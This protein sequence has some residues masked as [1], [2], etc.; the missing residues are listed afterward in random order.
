MLRDEVDYMVKFGG[1]V[2]YQLLERDFKAA[3]AN[4]QVKSILFYCN[5]PGGS[6]IIN[7]VAKVV[8][9]TLDW[10]LDVQ[11]AIALRLERLRS[12]SL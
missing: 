11:Q 8:V 6:A 5:S 7:Y 1:A 3:L 2:S 4:D 9:G 12:G 10:G